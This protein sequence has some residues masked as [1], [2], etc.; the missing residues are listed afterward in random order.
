MLIIQ[1]PTLN[2]FDELKKKIHKISQHLHTISFEYL[3]VDHSEENYSTKLNKLQKEKNYNKIN[4]FHLVKQTRKNERGL[5]SRFGYE[6]AIKLHNKVDLI[7]IDSD[8]AHNSKEI[9]RMYNQAKK[10]NCDIVIASKYLKNSTVLNRK[11]SRRVI[12]RIYNYINK[13]IFRL[14]ITDTTN[15]YRY[16][17][18]QSLINYL[19][20]D[21]KF[22]TP[23]A[24]LLILIINN[25]KKLKFLEIDSIYLESIESR[26][27][28]N[29]KQLYYCLIDYIKLIYAFINK[30]IK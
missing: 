9:L 10:N 16:Y 29:I 18:K 21:L 25:N 27:S 13:I 4:Y 17:S 14:K 19:K 5:A 1:I 24:H 22:V 6:Q 12:S 7:E 26:S 28:I 30:K 20:L 8:S 11:F 23:I 2:N 15:G 3:I